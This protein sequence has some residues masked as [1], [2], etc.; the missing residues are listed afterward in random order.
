MEAIL[1]VIT[2]TVVHWYHEH[3]NPIGKKWLLTRCWTA[4]KALD[5]CCRL[6]FKGGPDKTG[7]IISRTV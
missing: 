7:E 3:K 1:P 5:N 2:A 4:I 6:V